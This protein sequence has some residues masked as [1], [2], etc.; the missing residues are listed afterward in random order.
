M[1]TSISSQ[2]DPE[3]INMEDGDG[4][5]SMGAGGCY[6]CISNMKLIEFIS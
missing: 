3:E 2:E 6:L 4:R 5:T 1:T